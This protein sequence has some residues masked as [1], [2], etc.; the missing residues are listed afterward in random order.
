MLKAAREQ[1]QDL[2]KNKIRI[3]G[4]TLDE[5]TGSENIFFYYANERNEKLEKYLLDHAKEVGKD[6][7]FKGFDNSIEKYTP[8]D[9]NASIS[10]PLL[11]YTETHLSLKHE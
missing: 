5:N 11:H 7:Q 3:G 9:V 2:P 10:K 8:G 4:Y 6:I 1:S